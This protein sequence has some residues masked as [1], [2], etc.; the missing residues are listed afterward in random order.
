V[1]LK[2]VGVDAPGI[3]RGKEGLLDCRVFKKN[4]A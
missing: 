4:R 2:G 3:P 1:T